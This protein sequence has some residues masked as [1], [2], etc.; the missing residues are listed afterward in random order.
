MGKTNTDITLSFN[1]IF[2][3]ELEHHLSEVFR[4]CS[5]SKYDIFWCDGVKMPF[6]DNQLT[7]DSIFNTKQ[8]TTHAFIGANGQGLYEM[9]IKLGPLS[10]D[11]CI[12]DKSLKDCLPGSESMEWVKLD[13][14]ANMIELQLN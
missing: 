2:C 12:N 11:A 7:K 13:T 6:L 3:A 10:I 5:I 14:S 1:E 8:I 4:N 9:I